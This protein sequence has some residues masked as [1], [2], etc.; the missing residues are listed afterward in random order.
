MLV[1]R[2]VTMDSGLVKNGLPL[3][4]ELMVDVNKLGVNNSQ[5][6]LLVDTYNHSKLSTPIAL[7]IMVSS[8]VLSAIK[9][10][11]IL[12]ELADDRYST[13]E[14][15]KKAVSAVAVSIGYM[16]NEAIPLDM[17]QFE[18][19]VAD[20][21]DRLYPVVDTSV[22]LYTDA[23]SYRSRVIVDTPLLDF[24]NAEA[25]VANVLFVTTS[26]CFGVHNP[27]EIVTNDTDITVTVRIGK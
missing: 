14:L 17:T 26:S 1:E 24:V 4:Y 22:L 18:V 2:G 10:V 15:Y 9:A 12:I 3:G 13:L 20:E 7:S 27:V 5:Y 16:I 6:R 11:N 8:V 25:G 19:I 21:L 23:T